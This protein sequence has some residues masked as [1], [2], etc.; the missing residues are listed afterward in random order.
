MELKANCFS[1]SSLILSLDLES[2]QWNWK[3]SPSCSCTVL[4]ETSGIHSMELKEAFIQGGGF[5]NPAPRIHSME[6]KGPLDGRRFVGP[7]DAT[8]Y[9][10]IQW[11]WKS[12]AGALSSWC[13]SSARIHSMELKE[14][15]SELSPAPSVEGIHSM[16]LKVAVELCY[17]THTSISE[18][19]QWNW[20]PIT[21]VRDMRKVLR[22]L[23]PFNGI[24]SK[25]RSFASYMVT[26]NPFNGIERGTC[27]RRQPP[28]QVRLESIQ[29]N[30]KPVPFTNMP[31]QL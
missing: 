25:T 27:S 21:T 2:I 4:E 7:D 28:I 8:V 20:K 14:T 29:W 5:L 26:V 19:I 15:A 18:S 23:N 30:W 12:G 1:I 13:G 16:E 31:Y 17:N 22:S 24:E 9:E 11:N 6:L 10:S 3:G